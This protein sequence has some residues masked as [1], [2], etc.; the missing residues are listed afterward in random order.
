MVTAYSS[1][2]GNAYVGLGLADPA[3]SVLGQEAIKTIAAKYNKT[4]AQI[5]LRW[6]IQRN[7]AII[8]KST[9]PERM[10]ENMNILDFALTDEEMTQISGLNRNHR[11]SDPGQ[12]MEKFFGL[13]YPTYD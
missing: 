5:A 12:F 6:A 3:D 11:Y 13:F 8:P 2:G 10:Q 1:M 9:K 4:E 7:T